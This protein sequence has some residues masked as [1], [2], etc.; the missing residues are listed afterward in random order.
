MVELGRVTL[1]VRRVT[2]EDN[3]RLTMEEVEA[4]CC[5]PVGPD[6]IVVVEDI[7]VVG[8]SVVDMGVDFLVQSVGQNTEDGAR[9]SR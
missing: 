6:Y 7:E 5:S 3:N 8:S 9:A 4:L 2:V 1:S